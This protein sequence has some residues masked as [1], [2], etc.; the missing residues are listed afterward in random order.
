VKE[1]SNG[2]GFNSQQNW[3]EQGSSADM[4]LPDI[5]NTRQKELKERKK[6]K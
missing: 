3:V 1:C 5:P 2:E 6:L 4:L